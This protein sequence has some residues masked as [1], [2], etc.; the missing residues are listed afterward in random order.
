MLNLPLARFS[1]YPATAPIFPHW[2]KG[3]DERAAQAEKP[4]FLMTF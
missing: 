4:L 1:R 2:K 3:L